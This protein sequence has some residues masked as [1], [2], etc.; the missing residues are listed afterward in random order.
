MHARYHARRLNKLRSSKKKNTT[1]TNNK[2]PWDKQLYK[3]AILFYNV[4]SI[5]NPNW[6][7]KSTMY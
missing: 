3:Y 7:R 5:T 1:K 6:V 2:K 4:L